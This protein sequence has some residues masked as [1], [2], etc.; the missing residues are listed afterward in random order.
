MKL[1]NDFNKYFSKQ[2]K[3][4]I[5]GYALLAISFFLPV[6]DPENP[7]QKYNLTERA[8]SF[9][10]M[11]LP[12]IVSVY[13]INC[14]VVG[15]ANGGMPCN[16]LAW[17]NGLSVLVWSVLVLIFTIMLLNNS[18]VAVTEVEKFTCKL[19]KK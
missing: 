14:M 8:L 7:H 18:N 3:L 15:K 5:V 10:V 4:A 16:V 9:V 19:D 11:L 13:T 6:K 17:L 12:M 1:V 2:A